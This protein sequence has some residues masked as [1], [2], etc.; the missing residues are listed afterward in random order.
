MKHSEILQVYNCICVSDFYMEIE[1]G[2]P[3]F[4]QVPGELHC[5]LLDNIRKAEGDLVAWTT[6]DLHRNVQAGSSKE[7]AHNMDGKSLR[8]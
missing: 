7:H 5:F 3:A 4:H 6:L 8:L 2:T 1:E